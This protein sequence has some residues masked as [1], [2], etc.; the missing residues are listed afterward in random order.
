M[1][2]RMWAIKDLPWDYIGNYIE[3]FYRNSFQSNDTKNNEDSQN[4][5][6]IQSIQTFPFNVEF[7]FTN[8]GF[9]FSGSL[10]IILRRSCAQK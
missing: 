3:K 10:E 7:S 1:P 6:D 9:I 8:S 4:Y 2:L 5:E